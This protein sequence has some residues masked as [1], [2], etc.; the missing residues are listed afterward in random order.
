MDC[1][2]LQS[3]QLIRVGAERLGEANCKFTRILNKFESKQKFNGNFRGNKA[4]I[5]HARLVGP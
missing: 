1:S 4:F 3:S 2:A 5:E